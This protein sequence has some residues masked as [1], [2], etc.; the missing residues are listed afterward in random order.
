MSQ[1]YTQSPHCESLE[2]TT[3]DILVSSTFP[4]SSQE[5]EMFINSRFMSTDGK[6]ADV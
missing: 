2:D 5:A 3:G 6:C 4:A 1:S